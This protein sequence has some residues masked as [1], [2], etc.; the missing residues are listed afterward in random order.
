MA[1]FTLTPGELSPPNIIKAIPRAIGIGAQQ[2]TEQTMLGEVNE[3]L[4]GINQTVKV[5][6]QLEDVPVFK[7]FLDQYGISFKGKTEETRGHTLN[8]EHLAIRKA[9]TSGN[10]EYVPPSSPVQTPE[11]PEGSFEEELEESDIVPQQDVNAEALKK[12]FKNAKELIAAMKKMLK[13]F[14]G[15]MKVQDLVIIV[16]AIGQQAG[17]KTITEAFEAITKNEKAAEIFLNMKI[18]K[19][20]GAS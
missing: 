2:S 8:K 6:G 13:V 11:V 12:S 19:N 7:N 20:G 10:T 9:P 1:G 4:K 3:I 16:A 18:F 14:P 5:L 17:D 15:D